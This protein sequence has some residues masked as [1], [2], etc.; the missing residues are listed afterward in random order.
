MKDRVPKTIMY[1]MVN[2]SKEQIQNELV[3]ELYKEELLE[4]L[5]EES[6]DVAE[7]RKYYS[8]TIDILTAAQKILNEINDYKIDNRNY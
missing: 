2:N 1:F 7:R 3:Q 6:S 8:Q 4:S 5:L